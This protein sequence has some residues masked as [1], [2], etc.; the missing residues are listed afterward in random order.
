MKAYAAKRTQFSHKILLSRYLAT[1]HT[2]AAGDQNPVPGSQVLVGEN[3]KVRNESSFVPSGLRRTG[4]FADG[5][6]ILRNEPNS[7]IRHCQIGTWPFDLAHGKHSALGTRHLSFL[8]LHSPPFGVQSSEFDVRYSR[9][10]LPV[11]PDARRG[12]PMSVP[13]RGRPA[14]RLRAPGYRLLATTRSIRGGMVPKPGKW[15]MKSGGF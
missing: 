8:I 7:A 12:S 5:R 14:R 9:P 3:L 4:P 13:P 15:E 11:G 2:G 10:S 6:P 1:A